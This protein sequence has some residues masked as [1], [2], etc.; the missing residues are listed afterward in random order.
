MAGRILFL[1][2]VLATLAA[3]G[4]ASPVAEGPGAAPAEADSAWLFALI[5][6]SLSQAIRRGRPAP[7]R[8]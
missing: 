2:G 8:R 1:F 3:V 4:A 5:A 7:T 6:L